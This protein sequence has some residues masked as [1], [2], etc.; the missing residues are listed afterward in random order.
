MY[1]DYGNDYGVMPT[2]AQTVQE[3]G[4]HQG[5][6]ALAAN[7]EARVVAE[8]KAQVLMARQFPR[9][10]MYARDRILREC[11]RPSLAEKAV[12]SF[13]RG[14]DT[15]SG[16]SIRLAEVLARNWG[17][18]TFGYEVLDRK[19]PPEPGAAGTSILRAY[20]WDL[21]TNTYISRQFE[22]KHWR[23]T[24]SGG[25]A[26]K[27]DRDI[28]ELESNMASR[29]MRACILQMI[30][31]DLT[32]DAVKACRM[33]ESSGLTERMKDKNQREA[34]ISKT[35]AIFE[36]MG[37]SLSDLE[38][39]LQAKKDDWQADQMLRLKEVINA[40]RDNVTPIGDFFPRLASLEK[41]SLVT[42]DQVTNL[43][44]AIRDTGKQGEISDAMKKMGYA[45]VADVP[46][47]KYEEVLK[48]ITEF[49]KDPEPAPET[50]SEP[51]PESAGDE[52]VREMLETP[53]D[54]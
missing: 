4:Y 54:E 47:D 42:K 52:E 22:V 6:N 12:Y 24:K 16:P 1:D 31:G 38:D 26:L 17:N 19:I 25:Y 9:D 50:A 29:R 21:E 7:S 14:K 45:K 44:K 32:S 41:S 2:P 20:A 39:L 48:Y 33:T 27:E 43:M 34:L 5:G 51:V 30:P 28:Y 36:K 11:Q 35:V 53:V 15:V 13:V 10:V 23:Q 40:I 49:G 3:Q 37:A 46:A 18:C 8:V